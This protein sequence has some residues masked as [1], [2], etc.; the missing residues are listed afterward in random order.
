MD[1][2]ATSPFSPSEASPPP[3]PAPS[4]RTEGRPLARPPVKGPAPEDAW[5][6]PDI[7]KIGAG[8]AGLTLLAL[9]P[10]QRSVSRWAYVGVGSA[11]VGGVVIGWARS[12]GQTAR[13]VLRIA[14]GL[15]LSSTPEETYALW[16]D[17]ERWPTFM[18]H[19]ERVEPAGAGR[20]SWRASLA[21]LPPLEWTSELV[22]DEP[23]RALA[24]RTLPGASVDHAGR[25]SFRALSSGRGTGVRLELTYEPPAGA[26][27]RGL[28]ALLQ[29][30]T[31]RLIRAD[32]RRLKSVLEAGEVPV[33]AIR[34]DTSEAGQR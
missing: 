20:W 22:Q 15:Q 9:A 1:Q 28:A 13:R 29:P 27:G 30:A 12:N 7:K 10:R 18:T 8:I 25:V 23:G 34:A 3:P 5:P 19:L 33:N 4:F 26:L 14:E 32:V 6:R 16:R 31:E 21:G 24:W 2:P 11:L 17:F